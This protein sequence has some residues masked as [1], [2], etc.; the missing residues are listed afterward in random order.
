MLADSL[1]PD[2]V[3]AHL[4]DFFTLVDTALRAGPSPNSFCGPVAVLL[5]GLSV[6]GQHANWS[7]PLSQQ[8]AAMI[9]IVSAVVSSMKL[10]M[11][12]TADPSVAWMSLA[13][14]GVVFGVMH[15]VLKPLAAAAAATRG[16]NS[17]STGAASCR[18]SGSSSNMVNTAW[19]QQDAGRTLLLVTIARSLVLLSDALA[20]AA[21]WLAAAPQAEAKPKE[22]LHLPCGE[23]VYLVCSGMMLPELQKGTEVCIR[24]SQA[25]VLEIAKTVAAGLKNHGILD[26]TAAGCTAAPQMPAA[27]HDGIRHVS[28]CSRASS[29]LRSNSNG[30]SDGINTNSS[31]SS[32]SSSANSSSSTSSDQGEDLQCSLKALK[33]SGSAGR[34]ARC[35][36]L[37]QLGQSRKLTAAYAAYTAKWPATSAVDCNNT[38]STHDSG[39]AGGGAAPVATKGGG[40]RSSVVKSPKVCSIKQDTCTGEQY[41]DA[42]QFCRVL[43][44]AVPLPHICNNLD[45]RSLSKTSEAA[46]AVKVCS[47]CGAWYCCSDCAVAHWLR[48]KQ[49][50]RRMAALGLDVNA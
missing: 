9:A 33:T 11:A 13:T 34:R 23:G 6:L 37:L 12:L 10:C 36:Y 48:H 16:T 30:T 44:D 40:G 19:Q 24:R 2:L 42:V 22:S 45:C 7:P 29:K 43:V 39:S 26:G 32:A 15:D 25:T 35:S 21:A 14:G 4:V 38:T 46:A 5:Q 31:R 17:H 20:A 8:P 47:G 1:I 27:A 18:V 3:T 28:S 49:A 41:S 50:C